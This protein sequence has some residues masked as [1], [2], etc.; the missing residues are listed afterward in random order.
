MNDALLKEHLGILHNELLNAKTVD[1]DTKILLKEIREDVQT[2]LSHK[3]EYSSEHRTTIKERLEES[4]RH[5][6]VSHPSLAS[7]IKIV[8]NT[9]NNIGI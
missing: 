9:L 8:I 6:E 7:T 3:G 5:F 1:H 2:L 4:E